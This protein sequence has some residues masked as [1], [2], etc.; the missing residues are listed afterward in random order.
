[1]N[2]SRS[3]EIICEQIV[4]DRRERQ[5]AS[6][7][8]GDNLLS[9]IFLVQARFISAMNLRNVSM[10]DYSYRTVKQ[11]FMELFCS[12]GTSV[13]DPM[14]C[15]S[16]RRS[17][18]VLDEGLLDG[19]DG[20]G[21]KMKR[22]V[23]KVLRPCSLRTSSGSCSPIGVEATTIAAL[24]CQ[25]AS[26]VSR[27]KASEREKEAP[28]KARA[29]A[30]PAFRGR[31]NM[32]PDANSM[33]GKGKKGKKGGKSKGKGEGQKGKG[34]TGEDSVPSANEAAASEPHINNSHKPLLS[35]PGV[36]MHGI[37][38][39]TTGM[40]KMKTQKTRGG[41]TPHRITV[42][43]TWLLDYQHLSLQD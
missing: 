11:L 24:L 16:Q 5:K 19:E 7:P 9:L 36:Q 29:K 38:G 39:K 6:F 35:L 3:C 37:P 28:A 31:S 17:F 25:D 8:L 22:Q 13:A 41:Q 33:Y 2:S 14:M 12:T 4:T 21:F 43:S 15:R 40:I 20:F 30:D 27:P 32:T 26:F 34:K 23:R 10:M 18:L 42:T 1:M